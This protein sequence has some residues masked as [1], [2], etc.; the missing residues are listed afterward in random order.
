MP[1]TNT[2]NQL[3]CRW[4][5]VPPFSGPYLF[6]NFKNNQPTDRDVSADSFHFMLFFY[7]FFSFIISLCLAYFFFF[8]LRPLITL[9]HASVLFSFAIV[10]PLNTTF[11]KHFYFLIFHW[12]TVTFRWPCPCHIWLIYFYFLSFC[13]RFSFSVLFCHCAGQTF[14]IRF[15]VLI[16]LCFNS[17]SNHFDDAKL[18]KFAFFS[19]LQHFTHPDNIIIKLIARHLT[20]N[21]HHPSP[22]KYISNHK[23]CT[24]TISHHKNHFFFC[25]KTI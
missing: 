16:Y 18:T 11:A 21:M 1:H 19:I 10:T 2:N 22:F 8:Q 5:T 25:E 6:D 3:P 20:T 7:L 14:S 17:S 12:L 24:N 9:A 15:L 23:P 4:K 13:S